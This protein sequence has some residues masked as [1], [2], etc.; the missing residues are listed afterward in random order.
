MTTSTDHPSRD[1]CDRRR[2]PQESLS[3]NSIVAPELLSRAVTPFLRDHIPGVYAPLGKPEVSPEDSG[4]DKDTNSK[5]C[6]RH[7]PD[8]KCRKVA[9]ET[10]MSMIQRV[11]GRVIV[12]LSFPFSSCHACHYGL[13]PHAKGSCL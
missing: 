7:R 12:F 8:A 6:Y 9:D 5:F 13:Y 11:S 3:R 4:L 1:N 2:F 10:K